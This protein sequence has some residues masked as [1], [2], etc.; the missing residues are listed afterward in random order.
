M[1]VVVAGGGFSGS[2]VARHLGRAGVEVAVVSADNFL[3]FT[4]MLAEVAAGDVDPRHIVA[5]LRQL[6]PQAEV[7]QGVIESI[8]A[9]AK[10]VRVAPLFAGEAKTISGD[11]LVI[12]VGSVPN[13]FGISGA[14]EH[15]LAFKTIVDALRIRNRLL[16]QMEAR[17]TASV[18]IVG[19]GYSGAEVAAALADF[20]YEVHRRYYSSG[21]VP[22]VTLVDAV[23]R[24]TPALSPALSAKAAGALRRRGVDLMLGSAVATVDVSGLE[25]QNGRRL[26]T[27][28]VIWA[29]GVKAH[30]LLARSNLGTGSGRLEVDGYFRTAID[31]VFAVGDAAHAPTGEGGYSPPT[32][33]FALRQ[34]RFLGQNL[35]AIVAGRL[36]EPFRYHTKGELVSLGHHNAVGRVLGVPVSGLIGWFLWRTYYLWQLPTMLRRA[37]VAL[38]W[39][40]DVVFP[41]D[42]AWLPSSDLGPL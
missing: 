33:Q 16:A 21:P 23:E 14:E 38:D 17:N 8:D 22:E 1:R 13:T 7:V 30:P 4:P 28:N 5:P 29:A 3:L 35:P 24:V 9:E 39:T 32:A 36:P 20:L 40:L 31:G 26:Q 37:R 11:A 34:G 6:S 12:A 25:L 15:A 19:A 41:P 2:Q 18:A 10:S 27:D 42:I